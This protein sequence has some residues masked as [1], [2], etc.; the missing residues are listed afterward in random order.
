MV[1]H[2]KK[3]RR[4]GPHERPRIFIYVRFND[5]TLSAN[6]TENYIGIIKIHYGGVAFVFRSPRHDRPELRIFFSLS[7]FIRTTLEMRMRA[8]IRTLSINY[9][10]VECQHRGPWRAG[11]HKSAFLSPE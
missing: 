2:K 1:F 3:Q 10:F 11:R 6:R 5:L 9:L 4:I 7:P 8:T